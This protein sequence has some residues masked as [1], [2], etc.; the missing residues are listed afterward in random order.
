[1]PALTHRGKYAHNYLSFGFMLGVVMMFVLWVKDNIPNKLRS[2]VAGQG[3]RPVH[4]GRA[5]AVAASS[6]PA[7]SSS[8]GPVVLG[9][10]SISLSGIA[11][12]FPFEIAM[13]FEGTFKILNAFGFGLPDRP[14][15]MQEMQLAQLWHTSSRWS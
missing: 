2:A 5:S 8:S 7:R 9:G 1:M 3:R 15:P 10:I 12:L 11:L 4:Q 6:T 14:D 13:F